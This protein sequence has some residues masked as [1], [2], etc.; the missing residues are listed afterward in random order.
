MRRLVT[1][2]LALVVAATAFASTADGS[3]VRTIDADQED[4]APRT[5]GPANRP[6]AALVSQSQSGSAFDT[7]GDCDSLLDRIQT[8]ALSRV[9]A[10]GLDRGQFGEPRDDDDLFEDEFD[11]DDMDAMMGEGFDDDVMMDDGEALDFESEMGA[12][13][14]MADDSGGPLPDAAAD[15]P[16]AAPESGEFSETNV[17]VAGV[18]EPDIVKTDGRRIITV[19]KGVLTVVDVSGAEPTTTGHVVLTES[20]SGEVLLHGDRALVIRNDNGSIRPGEVVAD[21][22]ERSREIVVI[23]EVLLD[24]LPRRG[25]SLRIEGRYVSSRSIGATARIVINS[26]PE[27]PGFVRPLSNIGV[28]V[29]ADVNRRVIEETTLDDWLPD[30]T[31]IDALGSEPA[32]T[33]SLLSCER[34]HVPVAF[35]G[36]GTASVLTVDLTEPLA[37]G[38]GAATFAAA[39][40]VYASLENMYVA[41]S[42]WVPASVLQ[43][44]DRSVAFAD[45]Y[46]T[47][48]HK[49]SL[50]TSGAAEYQA[51][52][53]VAG[54][55]LNQFALHEFDRHLFVA[56][57]DG[58]PWRFGTTESRIVALRQRGDALVEVGQVGD[59]G[60]GE[61]IFAV[62]YIADRAYVVTYRQVDPLYVVDLGDPTQPAVL[63]ELKIPGFSSYLHPI[64]DGLLVGV[65]RDVTERGWDRGLKIS[66]FDVADA[67]DP[68]EIDTWTLR[69]AHSEVGSDHRSF[70]W[71]GRD[72]LMVLPVTTP[73]RTSGPNRAYAFRVTRSEGLSELGH[74]DHSPAEVEIST[75]CH[76]EFTNVGSTDM[77][78]EGEPSITPLVLVCRPGEEP[79]VAGYDCRHY[80][81]AEAP[82]LGIELE[83]LA[84]A[85][86]DEDRVSLCRPQRG[87]PVRRSL[88]VGDDLWT[89]S[90]SLLQ[91]N[92]LETLRRGDRLPL[93]AADEVIPP[94]VTRFAD[95]PALLERIRTQA[96][97][98]VGPHGFEHGRYGRPSRRS[99]APGH[100][101]DLALAFA[102]GRRIVT[103]FENTLTVTDTTGNQPR[104]VGSTPLDVGQPLRLLLHGNRAIVIGEQSSAIPHPGLTSAGDDS[105]PSVVVR[106]FLVDGRP[107]RGRSLH[108]EGSFVA[109]HSDDGTA[110]VV[111]RSIPRD[112]GFVSA[113]N[114]SGEL[115]AIEANRRTLAQ[116]TLEDWLPDY[117][118]VAA[119]GLP[120]REGRLLTC[121]Q[122][123]VPDQFSG[124]GTLSV[125]MFD[126]TRSIT[127]G[128]ATAIFAEGASAEVSGSSLDV[129]VDPWPISRPS[130][131]ERRLPAEIHSFSLTGTGAAEY[132]SSRSA[133]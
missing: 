128:G 48:I 105:G 35:S 129:S 93:P 112:L 119:T 111:I 9:S 84:V 41:T 1:I 90:A 44:P 6:A 42:D 97:S 29:A 99:P 62:R 120:L 5:V 125:V 10:D 96:T 55:L 94:T 33:E 126:P 98:R 123:I 36:F 59:M 13:D 73:G 34:V 12:A 115:F 109:A 113:R 32:Q 54:H 7:F 127:V 102:D 20:R 71:W 67:T 18:D 77:G 27:D 85:V 68:Q 47:S 132:R 95:C 101:M 104:V 38:D 26:F 91:Q 64:G 23:D 11:D 37:P 121:E 118:L 110:R 78:S 117:A 16:A 46:A 25:R 100:D 3:T 72:Q 19:S 56:T 89:M 17:Q 65:G 83:L 106:E 70:L 21:R 61:R 51:S 60:R 75:E 14:G 57:T 76:H 74:I 87:E 15:S 79:D 108:V 63:G 58:P 49:F 133:P 81:P 92:D 2:T 40:T 130:G 88:I 66:L 45:G 86:N 28:S 53:S 31:L 24:G 39:E 8:E 131:G 107:Q 124:F 103:A 22:S 50:H 69:D 52:G 80:S 30:Y 116:A 43:D 122:V 4:T 114:D 82:G